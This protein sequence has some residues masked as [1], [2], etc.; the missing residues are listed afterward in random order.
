MQFLR[1]FPK[2]RVDSIPYM[3]TLKLN[4]FSSRTKWIAKKRIS[5][6]TKS[7]ST[8]THN[9]DF[10]ELHD[11]KLGFETSPYSIWS[12]ESILIEK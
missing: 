4:L 1:I 12:D 11:V 3:S 7:F 2:T 10:N 6:F 8:I 5:S 9:K